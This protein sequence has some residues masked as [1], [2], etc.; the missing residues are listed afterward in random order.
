MQNTEY[1]RNNRE[2]SRFCL[3]H[4]TFFLL[5]SVVCCP[6]HVERACLH[7]ELQVTRL[8]LGVVQSKQAT[9]DAVTDMRAAA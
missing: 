9:E 7:A 2:E 6:L 1:R 5:S 4:S 8:R 3:L